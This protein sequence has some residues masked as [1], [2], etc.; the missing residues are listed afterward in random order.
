MLSLDEC[1]Q[2]ISISYMERAGLNRTIWQSG[3]DL[4]Q[5][6]RELRPEA[7][8]PGKNDEARM[9]AKD[10]ALAADQAYQNAISA[11]NAAQHKLAELEASIAGVEAQRRAAEWRIRERMVELLTRGGVDSQSRGD[12]MEAVFD[13][14]GQA[15]ADQA[16]VDE[17][18]VA[19][20]T[21]DAGSGPDGI[22]FPF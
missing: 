6:E 20:D 22:E 1:A 9:A 7:G 15:G 10:A 18:A 3:Q 14:V 16:V 8:W 19:G 21:L 13:D 5:R 17:L 11:R 12:R 4:A 2:Q